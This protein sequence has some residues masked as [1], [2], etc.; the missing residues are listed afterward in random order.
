MILKSALSYSC[1]KWTNIQMEYSSITVVNSFATEHYSSTYIF[2]FNS[3]SIDDD[4]LPGK[5]PAGMIKNSQNP[6]K[7]YIHTQ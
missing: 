4:M 2:F 1:L 5:D 6:W 7:K 3:L